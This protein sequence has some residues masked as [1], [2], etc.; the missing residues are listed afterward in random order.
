V[1][2]AEPLMQILRAE[3]SGVR[4]DLKQLTTSPFTLFCVQRALR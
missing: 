1:V 2:L 3:A 4:L